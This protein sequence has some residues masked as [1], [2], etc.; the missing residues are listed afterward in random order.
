[1]LIGSAEDCNGRSVEFWKIG[2][3][4]GVRVRYS[5]GVVVWGWDDSM[6][7][8]MR[9]CA[10]LCNGEDTEDLARLAIVAHS[11]ARNFLSEL[12]TSLKLV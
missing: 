9:Q 10:K 6:E 12:R 11:K 2:Q 7:G 5:D 8:L 4:Y 1:M 3:I